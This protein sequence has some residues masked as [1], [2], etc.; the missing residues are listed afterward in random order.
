MS[1]VDLLPIVVILSDW[2][3]P[4]AILALK[5][6]LALAEQPKAV[7]AVFGG[8]GWYRKGLTTIRRLPAK[9]ALRSNCAQKTAEEKDE[10][11]DFHIQ[12]QVSAVIGPG[13]TTDLL[14]L[15]RV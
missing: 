14:L 9:H 13:P 12:F 1:I 6:G 5:S 4:T 10:K 7:E 2:T 11:R 8:S 15:E 3:V